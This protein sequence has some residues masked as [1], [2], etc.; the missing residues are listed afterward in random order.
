MTGF[1]ASK[2]GLVAADH[3]GELAVLGA[4]LAAGDRRV[5]EADAACRGD[6]RRSSRAT[7]AEAVVLSMRIAP[8]FMPA[9]A[10][11]GADSHRRGDR[12][13]CRRR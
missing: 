4:R 13:R 2:I 5:E 9:S 10:P 1:A 12:R 8:F 11:S 6:G 3:D 7:V